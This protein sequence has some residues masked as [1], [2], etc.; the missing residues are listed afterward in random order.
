MDNLPVHW[1]EGM[2]LRSHHLQAAQ[3]QLS[4]RAILGEKW[5]L[6][7][8]WGLRSID[9]NLDALSNF[10]FEVK[11]LRARL[12]DGTLVSIPQDRVLPAVDLKQALSG[13][14]KRT[15]YLAV[16][17]L[18][19][20]RNN[21]PM[22]GQESEVRYLVDS[23]KMEDENTGVNPQP[24][25]FR[26]PNARLLTD[27]QDHAGYDTLPIARIVRSSRAEAIPQ[28]DETYFPPVLACDAWQPLGTELVRAIYDRVGRKIERLAAQVI[29]RNLSFESQGRGDSLIFAQ[30]REMNEA[31]SLLGILAFA[32]GVHPLTAYLEL[33]RLVGQLAIFDPRTRRPPSL[34]RYD[35]DDLAGCFYRA[36]QCL[37]AL[38][39]VVVE[40]EYKE[41]PFIGAGYRMQVQEL[42]SAWLESGWEMYIG[43]QSQLDREECIRILTSGGQLDMKVGSSQRV[44]S[45]FRRGDA[46]LHFTHD[47]RPPQALPARAGLIF[48]Q[49]DRDSEPD[50]WRHVL[51]ERSLAIRLNEASIAGNIQDQTTLTIKLPGGQ[52]GTME[53]TLFV[54]PRQSASAKSSGG[55]R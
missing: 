26:R 38:L 35:H 34:P 16:P 29:S 18:N 14:T 37:D 30:L 19:L 21:I 48:F 23:L 8:N 7:Y 36:K 13:S 10:R 5:D 3:R 43:V 6:H 55:G 2:F 12:R 9:L 49:I 4:Q 31:Y 42:D 15:I 20:S 51:D 45:I 25:K 28:L 39:D 22:P 24:I 52:M 46:G 11:S 41:R 1:E 47:S 44:D 54:V 53:F 50:E 17:V 27:E 33:A 32:D 40:P